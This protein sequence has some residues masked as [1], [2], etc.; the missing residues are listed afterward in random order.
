MKRWCGILFFIAMVCQQIMGH[1]HLN[2]GAVAPEEGSRLVFQNGSSYETNSGYFFHLIPSTTSS[3]YR[4]QYFIGAPF[5]AL[6]ATSDL[7]GPAAGHAALGS[8]IELEFVS[9]SGPEGGRFSLWET[10][11]A[12][13]EVVL[14]SLEAG[15]TNGSARIN[16]SD[17]DKSPGSDPWGHIHGRKMVVDK[18]GLYTIGVRLIDSSSNGAGNQPIHTP[19]EIYYFHLLTLNS[20][21][22]FRLDEENE[23]IVVGVT[24]GRTFQLEFTGG[25]GS[26]WNA[27]GEPLSSPENRLIEVMQPKAETNRIYRLRIE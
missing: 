19:S 25:I 1:D 7:G 8:Y 20:I 22:G 18:P 12:I 11:S 5:T 15:T 13:D 21:A 9:L 26:G 27:I 6:A 16:L 10:L 2:A 3:F 17:S 24:P 4:G 14:L 23:A